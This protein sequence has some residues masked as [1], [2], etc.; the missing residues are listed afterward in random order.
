MGGMDRMRRASKQWG[1]ESGGGAAAAGI[2][3]RA[4]PARGRLQ[5]LS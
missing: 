4:R 5:D 1:C 2:S 3:L